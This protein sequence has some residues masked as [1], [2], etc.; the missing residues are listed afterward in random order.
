[1]RLTTFS[2]MFLVALLGSCTGPEPSSDPVQA[3]FSSVI[4]KA[5]GT[6]WS[7]NDRI[8]VFMGTNDNVGAGTILGGAD[9]IPY[10]VKASGANGVFEASNS[11][12]TIFLP[13]DGSQVTFVAY[14]PYAPLNHY[15]LPIDLT[16]QSNQEALDVMSATVA[17]VSQSAP[18]VT[19]AFERAMSKVVINATSSAYSAE[20]MNAMTTKITGLN[21]VGR[22]DLSNRTLSSTGNPAAIVAKAAVQGSKYEAI[23]F[24]ESVASAVAKIEFEIDGKTLYYDIQTTNF[25]KGECYTYDLELETASVKSLNAT[26]KDWID[27]P[28]VNNGTAE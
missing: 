6:S 5:V 27:D 7:A 18:N 10:T 20:Q 28:T 14:Y 13:T 15:A 16:D 21:S 11:A 24:P 8:G 1:M 19:L 4:S 9:N 3:M 17:G 26:I 22:F 23:L 2:A 25:V 12:Q